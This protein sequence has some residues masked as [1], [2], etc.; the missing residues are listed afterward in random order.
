VLTGGSSQLPGM[1]TVAA[2]VL[3]L[4]VRIAHPENVTGM[5]EVLKNPAYSTSVGLLKLG[6]IMD[7]E[8][9]RRQSIRLGRNHAQGPGERVV[10]FFRGMFDRLLPG[11]E[12][13][14]E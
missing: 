9:D 11:E 14:E 7:L 13:G 2:E 8:D 10:G 12:T 4:P 6:L 3:K 1:K 5:A